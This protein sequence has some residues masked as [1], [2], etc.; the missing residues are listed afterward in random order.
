MEHF[1]YRLNFCEDGKTFSALVKTALPQSPCGLISMLVD[2][3]YID[4]DGKPMS[5]DRL[6]KALVN[7]DQIDDKT[8][9]TCFHSDRR[10]LR[11]R[12]CD[13][14]YFAEPLDNCRPP[15]PAALVLRTENGRYRLF[16]FD[17]DS[18][19]AEDCG[20]TAF[21]RVI[22]DAIYNATG[23]HPSDITYKDIARIPLSI[24]RQYGIMP[25]GND[26]AALLLVQDETEPVCSSEG[27]TVNLTITEVQHSFIRRW[28]NNT[29]HLGEDNTFSITAVFPDG[30]QMDIKCCGTKD[31]NEGAWTEAVLF[32]P[33]GG[34][35]CCT[36]VED[37]FLGEWE[38][39]V[40][41]IIYKANVEIKT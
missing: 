27:Y 3:G 12:C 25:R 2:S 8:A 9:E 36:D 24:L 16:E 17:V 31:E 37:R 7:F 18:R 40:D 38:L 4:S 14:D 32:E 19:L 35:I 21:R 28:I 34:E 39:E 6:T 41:G 1:N 11:V 23:K 15:Q 30:R 29:D 22:M 20:G 26:T 33:S 5:M 10:K 13:G